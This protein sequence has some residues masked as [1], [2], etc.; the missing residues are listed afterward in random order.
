MCCAV[1]CCCAVS[2]GSEK[3]WS[4]IQYILN[5]ATLKRPPSADGKDSGAG[6]GAGAG[7][8][9]EGEDEEADPETDSYVTFEE[10]KAALQSKWRMDAAVSSSAL[11]QALDAVEKQ[12]QE[13][14]E[15]KNKVEHTKDEAAKVCG[16]G[17]SGGRGSLV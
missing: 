5:V 16:L 4:N 11:Q 6:A 12:R 3:L 15:W 10:L 8:E 13:T 9:G 17:L 1:L 14:V 2:H 7:D